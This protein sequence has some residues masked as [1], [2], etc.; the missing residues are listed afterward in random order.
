MESRRR[1]NSVLINMKLMAV[2]IGLV[3]I[4]GLLGG[5]EAATTTTNAKF[6]KATVDKALWTSNAALTY[7]RQSVTSGNIHG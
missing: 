2:I 3:L 1:S 6:Q 5:P 7:V 4:L